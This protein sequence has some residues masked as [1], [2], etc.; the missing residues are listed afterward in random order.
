MG[1]HV[2][3]AIQEG[4][5]E[6]QLDLGIASTSKDCFILEVVWRSEKPKYE[7]FETEQEAAAAK[8]MYKK[9]DSVLDAHI[10]ECRRVGE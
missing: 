6:S 7:R 2:E 3:T 4:K 8:K 5:G 10:Y 1:S 9:Y